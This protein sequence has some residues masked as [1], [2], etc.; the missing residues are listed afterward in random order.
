VASWYDAGDMTNTLWEKVG[1]GVRIVSTLLSVLSHD[2]RIKVGGA[3]V[4]LSSDKP[5]KRVI[6][7]ACVNLAPRSASI[8]DS[9]VL[10]DADGEIKLDAR[11]S[12]VL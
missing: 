10:R 12:Y 2:F 3:S 11:C 5:G 7:H 4:F 8:N 9:R 1:S 6:D